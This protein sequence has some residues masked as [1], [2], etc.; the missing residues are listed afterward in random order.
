MVCNN[1]GT[2][3]FCDV[4]ENIAWFQQFIGLRCSAAP[5]VATFIIIVTLMK[6]VITFLT[7]LQIWLGEWISFVAFDCQH[8]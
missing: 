6:I 2:H 1:E 3:S 4:R 7:Y 5:Y 8:F